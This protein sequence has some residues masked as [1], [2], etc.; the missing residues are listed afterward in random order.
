[1]TS[2][3]ETV[4]L[5]EWRAEVPANYQLRAILA[6]V[7]E[8][9]DVLSADFEGLLFDPFGTPVDG[10]DGLRPAVPMVRRPGDGCAGLGFH[11][12][13]TARP[14]KTPNLETQPEPY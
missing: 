8:A 3:A 2:G 6:V 7:D 10:A 9:L 1:M 13:R 14:H 11:G 5:H 12:H 4:F